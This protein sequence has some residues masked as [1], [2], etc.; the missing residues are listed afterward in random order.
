MFLRH[1]QDLKKC[2]SAAGGSACR[3]VHNC[4]QPNLPNVSGALLLPSSPR[5]AG[6]ILLP[7]SSWSFGV[8]L[9]KKNKECE[10]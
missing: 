2:A 3:D 4:S 1:P 6:E 8:H 7:E 10:V 5:A 9:P